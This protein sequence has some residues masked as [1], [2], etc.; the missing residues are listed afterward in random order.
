MPEL[1]NKP[2]NKA[3]GVLAFLAWLITLFIGTKPAV[4][5]EERSVEGVGWGDEPERVFV[6]D[7]NGD[8][9]GEADVWHIS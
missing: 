1:I 8:V 6:R 4:S 7:E 2:G 3:A 5:M 9:I